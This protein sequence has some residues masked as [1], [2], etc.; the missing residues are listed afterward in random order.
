MGS[1]R[2]PSGGITPACAGNSSGPMWWAISAW[3]HPRVCGE[4]QADF[5]RHAGV[6]GSP[7]RVRGT[8]I[9][10]ADHRLNKRITP[11]CAGNSFMAY[12]SAMLTQD[13]PRVC[14]EQNPLWERGMKW[15]GSPPRVRGTGSREFGSASAHRIT[16]ACAGNSRVK[17]PCECGGWDHPR[18]CGEQFATSLCINAVLGSPPRVRGTGI[19]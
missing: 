16:P 12:S 1:V 10:S 9:C 15:A 2:H 11:A 13:H 17:E 5:R 8:D 14:G 6:H 3:D 18:V 4:Q 7:P 19:Q